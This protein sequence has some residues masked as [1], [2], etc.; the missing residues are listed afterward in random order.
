[1]AL[2]SVHS[3]VDVLA[4]T[5]MPFHPAPCRVR[6]LRRQFIAL[7][8]HLVS[9]RLSP[10]TSAAIYRFRTAAVVY[11][12]TPHRDTPKDIIPLIM[13]NLADLY[14]V[15]VFPRSTCFL[16]VDI[17]AFTI[18]WT[19]KHFVILH[20]VTHIQLVAT[21]AGGLGWKPSSFASLWMSSMRSSHARGS[22][23]SRRGS[24]PHRT[25]H[26]NSTSE[27]EN[28]P[29]LGGRTVL[30][31]VSYSDRGG[32]SRVLEL[33]MLEARATAWA[34]GLQRL[35]NLVPNTASPAHWRWS[36]SCMAATS[37]RGATG[38]LRSS[39]LRALLVRANASS[40][41]TTHELEAALQ[42]VGEREDEAELPQWL[43]GA[44]TVDS[45]RHNLLAAQKIAGLLFQLSTASHHITQQ[46]DE[47]AQQDRMS[48]AEWLNFIR[49][50]Q[51]PR[52]DAH[53]E[54]CAGDFRFDGRAELD[55]AL[56]RFDGAR[57]VELR[58]DHGFSKLQFALQILSVRN[59]AVAPARPTSDDQWAKPLAQYF[60]ATSHN[61]YLI[62]DQLT[63]T[64]TA[65]AYRR[66]LLQVCCQCQP[67]E[68]P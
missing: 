43:H 36:L 41:M 24:S 11:R 46:F 26:R 44:A 2:V 30:L 32:V 37:E 40:R 3:P 7:L 45:H 56:Q 12:P 5:T 67:S 19:Q 29:R 6:R 66:Q 18:R 49:T 47:Y 21:Q 8:H 4:H 16:Q 64:S 52:P 10:R 31:N 51:M 55:A 61:S 9:T 42:H 27:E 38:Y 20:A 25:P 59:D 17:D 35:L 50:E 57:S 34:H 14:I 39:E 53:E 33:R 13:G 68:P 23:D 54:G 60:T 1:M 62:G 63:G 22:R 58:A 15:K 28:A 65:G 48:R